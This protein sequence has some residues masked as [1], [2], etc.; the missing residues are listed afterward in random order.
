MDLSGLAL[1]TDKF[2]GLFAVDKAQWDA[3]LKD[4]ESFFEKFDAHMPQELHK[5]FDMLEGRLKT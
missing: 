5:E 1:A 3:E 2:D 4:T